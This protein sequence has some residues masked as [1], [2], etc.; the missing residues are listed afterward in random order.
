MAINVNFGNVNTDFSGKSVWFIESVEYNEHYENMNLTLKSK[1]NKTHFEKFSIYN[2]MGLKAFAGFC[3]AVFPNE[4]LDG[5]FDA[6]RLVGQFVKFEMELNKWINGSGEE[7]S[8]YRKKKGT[9][10]EHVDDSEKFETPWF[11]P[12]EETEESDEPIEITE[13]EDDP[14]AGLI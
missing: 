4:K 6:S 10:Y 12:V 3:K 2:E 1:N 8:A 13:D 14:L 11:T 7:K 5:D 9:Y